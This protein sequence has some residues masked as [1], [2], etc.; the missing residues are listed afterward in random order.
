VQKT[1]DKE[2]A[3]VE[4]QVDPQVN[5][6]SQIE[7]PRVGRFSDRNMLV[8]LASSLGLLL[9]AVVFALFKTTLY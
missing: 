9:F 7:K 8:V 2:E 6:T 5:I 1:P 4:P 3:E